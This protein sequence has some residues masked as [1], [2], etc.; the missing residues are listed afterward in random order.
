MQIH[1]QPSEL[2]NRIEMVVAQ[3]QP[4]TSLPTSHIIIIDWN[5]SCRLHFTV[6][7]KPDV[8]RRRWHIHF[9]PPPDVPSLPFAKTIAYGRQTKGSN[10]SVGQNCDS[11]G[12]EAT[13]D[14]L[15]GQN[16]NWMHTIQIQVLKLSSRVTRFPVKSVSP[17]VWTC[18]MKE[19]AHALSSRYAHASPWVQPQAPRVH[20]PLFTIVAK[21]WNEYDHRSV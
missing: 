18:L 3:K 11:P 5:T 12:G 13:F 16:P 15:N 10:I 17:E 9:G 14:E 20:W 7:K 4:K 2:R 8:A 21:M 6:D 19:T 1:R